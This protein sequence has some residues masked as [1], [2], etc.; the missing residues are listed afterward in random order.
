MP[1]TPDIPQSQ[2]TDTPIIE[3]ASATTSNKKNPAGNTIYIVFIAIVL[4]LALGSYQAA[5]R[6]SQSLQRFVSS[7][8]RE[9]LVQLDKEFRIELSEDRLSDDDYTSYRDRKTIDK[10][11]D[12]S[13][14]STTSYKLS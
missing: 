10:F 3:S 7:L 13:D 14:V 12:N 11:L 2:D 9:E 1:T 8:S 5:Q 6:I 4:V